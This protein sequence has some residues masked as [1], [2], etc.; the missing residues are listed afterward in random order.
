MSESDIPTPP[1]TQ[2]DSELS[3][4]TRMVATAKETLN[5]NLVANKPTPLARPGETVLK[6][7]AGKFL[8]TE[9]NVNR[10]IL[11][12]P[13]LSPSATMAAMVGSGRGIDFTQPIRSIGRM[14][15]KLE[16]T[17]RQAVTL[18]G[19][20]LSS[21]GIEGISIPTHLVGIKRAIADSTKLSDALL[22]TNTAA[23]LSSLQFNRTMT[24]N[25]MRKNL[26]LSYEGVAIA[27][28]MLR[29]TGAMA[30]MIESKLEAIKSNTAAPETSKAGLISRLK[31]EI[32]AQLV[33]NKATQIIGVAGDIMNRYV[34][35]PAERQVENLRTKKGLSNTLK[36][37]KDSV[38][39][40]T[41]FFGDKLRDIINGHGRRAGNTGENGLADALENLSNRISG[42]G[43]NI[44]SSN[45]SPD[46]QEKIDR[47]ADKVLSRI[48]GFYKDPTEGPQPPPGDEDGDLK[49]RKSSGDPILDTLMDIRSILEQWPKCKCAEEESPSRKLN[50]SRKPKKTPRSDDTPTPKKRAEPRIDPIPPQ[51]DHIPK[52][53]EVM[54]PPRPT[55]E[56][57]GPPRPGGAIRQRMSV[58]SDALNSDRFAQGRSDARDIYKSAQATVRLGVTSFKY[59]YATGDHP[60]QESPAQTEA[61]QT[62][63]DPEIKHLR[64][65][66][67][68]ARDEHRKLLRSHGV[69]R[70]G[71]AKKRFVRRLSPVRDAI[72]GAR[73]SLDERIS[74]LRENLIDS[75]AQRIVEITETPE[76]APAPVHEPPVPETPHSPE[77]DH[78][79]GLLDKARNR[80]T[81]INRRY[82]YAKV[83]GRRERMLRERARRDAEV[84]EEVAPLEP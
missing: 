34:K 52:P 77:P 30:D 43:K 27:K 79:D 75:L 1:V 18:P 84:S 53:K 17:A 14:V 13:R 68:S 58:L 26:A 38:G 36:D 62:E 66:R 11:R 32:R 9:E 70:L 39:D 8:R 61:E 31:S 74:P 55:P 76:P 63:E 12:A 59:H 37:V 47:Y 78:H 2:E 29:V 40:A 46:T 57:Y 64:E 83:H 7:D 50:V 69:R 73:E 44:K 16:Q 23:T 15:G 71:I 67:D 81:G 25:Y 80:L 10:S 60:D 35:E 5:S 72:S 6:D 21:G 54:G 3:R 24:A 41:T 82:R 4:P 51:A 19:S 49:L 22:S 65:S 42:W 20:K 33:K 45:F 48:P 56:M 28:S